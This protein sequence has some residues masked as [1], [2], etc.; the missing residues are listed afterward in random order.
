MLI[1]PTTFEDL[2]E[3]VAWERDTDTQG[4]LGKTGQAWHGSALTDSDQDHLVSDRDGVLSG[5]A[6]LAGVRRADRVV[7][8]RRVVVSPALRGAGF[9]RELLRGLLTRA[10][11]YHEASCVWLDV[12]VGNLRARSLY[13]SEGFTVNDAHPVAGAETDDVPAALIIMVHRRR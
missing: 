5:F 9:G 10:Y 12:K 4:W 2:P 13:E 11:K 6:V 1:R 8:I 3:L 7:E